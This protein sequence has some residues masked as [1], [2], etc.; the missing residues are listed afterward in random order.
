MKNHN[1]FSIIIIICISI[2]VIPVKGQNTQF[3]QYYS[4]PLYM[5]PSFA[6]L[7]HSNKYN[8]NNSR[9][10]LNYRDQWPN[11]SGTFVT[12]AAAYD[13]YF[14]KIKS[15]VG[16]IFLR[17]RAGTGDLSLTEIGLNYSRDVKLNHQWH[18]R[19]G[20]A[21]KYAGRS[22]NTHKLTFSDQINGD[23]SIAPATTD[24]NALNAKNTMYLDFAASFLLISK[25]HWLGVT[26]DHLT[27]PNQSFLH[28]MESKLPRKYS[29]FGGTRYD[30]NKSTYSYERNSSRSNFITFAFLYRMKQNYDQ[31]DI[32]ITYQ[33]SNLQLGIWYRGM[34]VLF[35]ELQQA[36]ENLDAVVFM[37]G[38]RLSE[39]K[40][41]I[42]YSYDF[43][44][45][46][47]MTATGGAHEISL[48][49]E[50]S[51]LF[52]FPNERKDTQVPC[53]MF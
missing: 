50:F 25:K 40:L 14:Q 48:M 52:R 16:I 9:V 1:I 18:F 27:Q 5:G 49:Y 23:W 32:G 37:L 10:T 22:L 28:N 43:T 2:T 3:S 26:I 4:A 39:Y 20:V 36:Y 38:Y 8:R 41:S 42:G 13:H 35:S 45:S 11:L 7:I 47:L 29:F 44:I 33:R 53:P 19:P 17:D 12:Y 21:F 46:E 31:L 6:G 24:Q 34:P 30:L 15:G 51:Q